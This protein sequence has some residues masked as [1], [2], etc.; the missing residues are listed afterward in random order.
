MASVT[1]EAVNSIGNRN[2]FIDY[3]HKD[4]L[5]SETFVKGDFEWVFYVK[6]TGQ[7][8]AYI[9]GFSAAGQSKADNGKVSVPEYIDNL[10]VLEVDACV[11]SGIDEIPATAELAKDCYIYE[12]DTDSNGEKSITIT[13]I[14]DD[15]PDEM[16]IPTDIGGIPVKTITEKAF[17]D[18]DGKNVIVSSKDV[19]PAGNYKYGD[20]TYVYSVKNL[21]DGRMAVRIT[22]TDVADTAKETG[23]I[24]NRMKE[25]DIIN[26]VEIDK[27]MPEAKAFSITYDM[28][29]RE[30]NSQSKAVSSNLPVAYTSADDD[31][32]IPVPERSGYIFRG[33]TV[34]GHES[35]SAK[36]DVVI[37]TGTEG[38]ISL[39]AHWEA[40]DS[41][42]RVMCLVPKL[43]KGT[44]NGYYAEY[45]VGDYEEYTNYD[46]QHASGN[47]NTINNGKVVKNITGKTGQDL[48]VKAPELEGFSLRKSQ[49]IDNT[50]ESIANVKIAKNSGVE[51]GTLEDVADST[52]N[53][54]T[55]TLKPESKNKIV[56]FVYS[57]TMY[58]VEID[59]AGGNVSESDMANYGFKK[60]GTSYVRTVYYGTEVNIP[61][62]KL[63]PQG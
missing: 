10:P 54:A 26:N 52:D 8:G 32:H 13:E 44:D 61:V 43:V 23:Y 37:P 3:A 29:D 11:F 4:I 18:A 20:Y 51:L 1:K 22:L 40:D 41:T 2:I 6:P 57:R 30:S 35:E 9:T 27:V 15:H 21:E 63:M 14:K 60:N 28:N 56:V 53:S 25:G 36:M 48:T 39:T 59:L 58:D 45:T 16:T 12:V 62:E 46:E 49:I 17:N 33:W 42:V 34:S 38:H 31:L 7:V 5:P 24:N 50:S 19:L 55:L 47:V